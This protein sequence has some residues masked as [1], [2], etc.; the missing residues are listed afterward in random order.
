MSDAIAGVLSSLEKIVFDAET[1]QR[2]VAAM[3]AQIVSDFA[4]QE[5]DVVALM[6][7]A[8][9]FVADLLR[10]VPLPVRVHTMSVRSYH[11]GTMS[12][13]TVQL[14]Q[15][16]PTG[17]EGRRVLLIDD[18]LDT[19]LTLATVQRQITETCR[20]LSLHS[21]VLLR[22]DR[23]RDME[24]PADYIGFDIPDEFVVGYGM[25][26]QGHY[27]NIPCIGVLSPDAI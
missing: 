1:I 4:G 25:D 15:Q 13:G 9:F 6:D 21:A 24:V 23:P 11:G 27:R 8:L 7:G 2:R 18:I 22:K 16:L 17:L 10:S 5:L 26:Y 20:P 3:A 19:G 12:T 14:L